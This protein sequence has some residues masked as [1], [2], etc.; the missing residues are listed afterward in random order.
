MDKANSASD[1]ARTVDGFDAIMWLKSAWDSLP[2][3]TIRK[4]FHNC[5]FPTPDQPQDPSDDCPE[6][7]AKYNNVLRDVTWEVFV[8]A[9]SAT[10]TSNI[11]EDMW[12]EEIIAAARGQPEATPPQEQPSSS[13]DEAA[14][15]TP[16]QRITPAAASDHLSA[17]LHFGLQNQNASLVELVSQCR[18]ELESM[19]A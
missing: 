2:D 14:E 19:Q 7:P 5:G 17:L 4:C 6:L 11:A 3:T 8:E 18:T 12:E 1:L 10:A 15:E 16:D 13:E 9:D